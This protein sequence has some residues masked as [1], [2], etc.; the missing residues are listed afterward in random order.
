[1]E[2]DLRLELG[3]SAPLWKRFEHSSNQGRLS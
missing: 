3:D 1:M 2:P